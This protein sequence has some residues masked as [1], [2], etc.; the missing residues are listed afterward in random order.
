LGRVT[1]VRGGHGINHD[2]L[3]ALFSDK[4]AWRF[5]TLPM[6]QDLLSKDGEGE[7][8]AAMPA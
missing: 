8:R 1:T 5:E 2:L 3:M 4:D 6:P 7:S